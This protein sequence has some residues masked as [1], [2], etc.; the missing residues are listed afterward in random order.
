[1]V[2]EPDFN[3]DDFKEYQ[4]NVDKLSQE[5]GIALWKTLEKID[6]PMHEAIPIS[7]PSIGIAYSGFTLMVM[8]RIT[9]GLPPN[10]A[11]ELVNIMV[12][13]QVKSMTTFL[14]DLKKKKK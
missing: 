5:F 11:K 14:E 1:M 8:D 13:T 10:Q 12:D 6:M 4:K 2:G 7:L 9:K 3:S